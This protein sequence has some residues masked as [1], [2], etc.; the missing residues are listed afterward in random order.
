[1][2]KSIK[3]YKNKYF[4]FTPEWS[5]FS[6]K[7]H[8]AGYFDSRPYLQ[9]YFIWGKLFLYLPWMHYKKIE[10]EK[11]DAE[12]RKDK[13]S[14]LK[15][16]KFKAKKKYVKE[17][18]DQSETP[19][20]GIYIFM[21]QLG[22]CL[23]DKVK[24]FDLPWCYEWIRTSILGKKGEWYHENRKNRDMN[25]YDT[26]KWKNIL[27]SETVPYTYITKSGVKQECLATIRVEER[28][29]RW[30]WFTWFK[31]FSKVRRDIDI[32]F[33]TDIGE[34]KGSW[35]G[36]VTGC[37]Y[38]LLKNETPIECLRRMERERKF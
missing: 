3:T 10:I 17:I 5:D 11:T 7:Y 23:G 22:I 16:T 28:E 30:K 14:K 33:S 18:Y 25:F 29:W 15:N 32:N 38:T 36:G 20:Y 21:N 2:I 34:R 35:K 19:S 9:I 13:L 24:L 37:S 8:V 4:E 27:Y 1:M 31:Y 12:K 26:N 6:L